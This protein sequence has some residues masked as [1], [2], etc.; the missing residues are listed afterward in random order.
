MYTLK[1]ID[2]MEKITRQ[3]LAD[4][5]DEILE[6]VQKENVGYVILDNEGNDGQVLCPAEWF[7]IELNDIP[8]VMHEL[9]NIKEKMYSLVEDTIRKIETD[10]ISDK[11]AIED[12][13]FMLMDY[14]DDIKF[15]ELYRSLTRV[16]NKKYPQC[17][18]G[19][20]E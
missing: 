18:K 8:S 13:Q 16:L 15:F 5:F 1:P 10:I 12:F 11:E 19:E 14:G 9:K 6:K 3:Y 17:K 2:T 4:N 7:K 20:F